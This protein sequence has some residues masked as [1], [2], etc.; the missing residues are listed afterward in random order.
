MRNPDSSYVQS[1]LFDK[2]IMSISDAI[3][4]LIKHNFKIKKI[5]ETE[6]YYRFR[7]RNPDARKK[8]AYKMITPALSFIFQ[9]K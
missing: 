5:D 8:Y 9:F 6:N 4:W 7:Q 3:E 2:D 1:I